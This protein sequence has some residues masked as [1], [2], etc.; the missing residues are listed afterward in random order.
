MKMQII[1]NDHLGVPFAFAS[2][3]STEKNS[4]LSFMQFYN[5]VERP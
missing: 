1:K 2:L 5:N 4:Q 3:K